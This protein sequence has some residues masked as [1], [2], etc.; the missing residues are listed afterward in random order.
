MMRRTVLLLLVLTSWAA[1]CAAD[2][3]FDL[4]VAKLSLDDRGYVT[5][6]RFSDGT[7][8]PASGQPAFWLE[9]DR[10]RVFPESIKRSGDRLNVAFS[11]GHAAEFQVAIQPGVAVFELVKLTPPS[12]VKQFHLFSL[13]TAKDGIAIGTLNGVEAGAFAAAVMAAEPNVEAVSQSA[14]GQHGDRAGCSHTFVPSDEAKVGRRAARFTAT[15]NAAPGGWSVVGKSLFKPLDLTGCKAIRAWVH[16]DGNRQ[17]LK[18]Q[19]TDN[20]GGYRDNYLTIDFSGWRQVTLVDSPVNSLRY[21]QV[22][23]VSFYYNSLPPSQTVS[24]LIDQVEAVVDRQGTEQVVLLEDFESPHSPLWSSQARSLDVRTGEKHGLT[25]ARF[26]VLVAPRAELLETVRR[27][28]LAARVPSP[29]LGGQWNKTSAAIKRS[30]FFLTSFG[31]DQFDEALAIARRGGF[32]MILM[33]QESWC[34]STGHYEVNRKHFPDGLEGLK[35]TIRKFKEA[36]FRVG[37]H[38]LGPSIYPPDPY[39]TPVPDPRLVKDAFTT[40]DADMDA[41]ATTIPTATAPTDF[42][43]EDKGYEGSGTVLQIGDELIFYGERSVT[44]PHGFTNCKRGYLGTKAAAHKKGERVAH[45]LRSYGYHMFD[46]DTSL[47]DEVA[48]NFAKVANACQIDMIYFDGSERL[49]GDHWYYNAK[50]HKAFYDKLENKNILLQASSFSHYSWHLLARSA[51]AD[52]HGD[53]K[54][55]L[56][57]RSPAFDWMARNGMPLDIGWYYGYDPNTPLDMYEYVLGATIGYNSS[58]SFQVSPAAAA[59]HPF[60]GEILDLISRYEKLRLSGRVGP[61]MKSLLRIDPILGGEKKPEDREKLRDK[62]RDYRLLGS[63]G[64]EVFQRVFYEPWQEV[65]SLDGKSNVWPVEVKPETAR[66]GVQIHAQSGPWL[67]PGPSYRAPDALMM[68]QFD[69]LVPYA[70]NAKRSRMRAIKS[71]EAGSTLPGVTLQLEVRDQGG[72]DGKR[73]AVYTADSSLSTSGGWSCIGRSLNPPL[74]ISWHRA[75]GLWLRGD[76]KGGAFKLQLLDG[77]RAADYYIQNNYTGWRYQQLARPANDPIDYGKVRSLLLYYNGLPA[78]SSVS[79]GIAG[80]KALRRL[81]SRAVVDPWVEVAGKRFAWKGALT[82]GQYL[83]F[84]PGEPVRVFGRPLKE[85]QLSADAWEDVSVPAGQYTARFGCAGEPMM[86]VRVR[87]TL[88]SSE[89]HRVP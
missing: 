39:L 58:M 28:E 7:Q 41:K 38:F 37:L 32:D 66:L 14:G 31:E 30:Y 69:D 49:Q 13:P 20:R 23:G 55:Y 21:H 62:R 16:G 25:P 5:P 68:E 60:T 70:P 43:A 44:A 33:G 45:L 48:T 65:T 40:L 89:R 76:G 56:D 88:Q 52:G 51:S 15:S 19:L 87:V 50:L 27:F 84:W 8:W 77:S 47:L 46:M 80:I 34:H 11:G 6:L 10:E 72:P 85:A 81:D 82:E 29:Q 67:N 61:A 71:G 17:L 57:E 4:G 9:T 64:H 73:C 75:I 35:R 79:C 18:I 42:P 74:D 54:G 59:A 63:E 1:A 2:S 12:G 78:K 24:C 22:R 86:P 36:G 83:F 53:L 3:E 26:G